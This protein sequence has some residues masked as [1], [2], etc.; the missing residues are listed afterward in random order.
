VLLFVFASFLALLPLLIA[1][2]SIPGDV[3]GSCSG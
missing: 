2:V 3:H 1:A